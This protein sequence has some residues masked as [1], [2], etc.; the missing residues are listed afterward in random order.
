MSMCPLLLC[1]RRIALRCEYDERKRKD[2]PTFPCLAFP[3]IAPAGSTCSTQHDI[4]RI[5][6]VPCPSN[7]LSSFFVISLAL[8][9][10]YIHTLPS[11]SHLPQEGARL[12]LR[13]EATATC[14]FSIWIHPDSCV[15]V[16]RRRGEGLWMQ[17]RT[18]NAV[19]GA[20]ARSCARNVASTMATEASF[21]SASLRISSFSISGSSPRSRKVV[22]I[23]IRNRFGALPLRYCLLAPSLSAIS[24]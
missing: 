14:S 19:R 18:F 5:P 4:N 13:P 6:F 9:S 15:P 21:A 1:G 12:L 17:A 3:D 20:L 2:P 8:P 11:L 23:Q 24:S 22:L 7:H 16:N 10:T